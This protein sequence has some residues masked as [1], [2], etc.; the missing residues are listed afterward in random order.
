MMRRSFALRL[1]LLM[2]IWSSDF[3]TISDKLYIS[4]GLQSKRKRLLHK[5]EK[6]KPVFRL[7]LITNALNDE[8]LFD[9]YYYNQLFQRYYQ[10]YRDLTVYGLAR[11]KEEAFDVVEQIVSDCLAKQQN[12]DIRT[13][14]E[15]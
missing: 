5:I 6:G 12:C 1:T 9:I 10:V 4:E 8:D 7:Y 14:M 2:S 13:F 15:M 3:M 11:T